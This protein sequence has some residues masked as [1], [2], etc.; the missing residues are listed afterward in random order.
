MCTDS[1]RWDRPAGD[2]TVVA[3]LAVGTGMSGGTS[4]TAG[5]S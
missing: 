4:R 3:A 1:D 2:A 5:C